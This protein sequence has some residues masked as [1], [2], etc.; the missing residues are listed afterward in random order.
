MDFW[1][2]ADASPAVFKTGGGA[3]EIPGR[4]ARR[5]T[6]LRRSRAIVS[7]SRSGRLVAIRGN[8][9]EQLRSRAGFL[10]ALGCKARC[11]YGDCYRYLADSNV[12]VDEA[13]LLDRFPP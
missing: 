13:Y 2:V 10:M 7:S 6:G 3:L 5:G 9:R 8:K 4:K 11:G 1:T 12:L